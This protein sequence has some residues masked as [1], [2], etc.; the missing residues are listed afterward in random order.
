MAGLLNS[1]PLYHSLEVDR[2]LE[3][4][5]D[6]LLNASNVREC[7]QQRIE[8]RLSPIMFRMLCVT[9]SMIHGVQ[10]RRL[11]QFVTGPEALLLPAEGNGGTR[12]LIQQHRRTPFAFPAYIRL[13]K[14]IY[15]SSVWLQVEP[16]LIRSAAFG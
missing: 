6:S 11:L 16:M 9:R 8:E 1:L 5:N 12:L 14:S 13:W 7:V 3:Q 4:D 2:S 10:A 15:K